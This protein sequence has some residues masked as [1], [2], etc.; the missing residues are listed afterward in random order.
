ML[1]QRVITAIILTSGFLIALFFLPTYGFMVLMA[2]TVAYGAWEWS[3]LANISS[4]VVRGLYVI[5]L[6][7]ALALSVLWL[8]FDTANKS[9]S[10]AGDMNAGLFDKHLRSMLA[11][12]CAWWALALLWIQG[13]PS[14]ALLWGRPWMCAV[15]GFLVLVPTWVALV[16]LVLMPD[17]ELLVLSVVLLV[18]LADIGAY[19]SGRAFGRHKLAE[20]VSPGKTWEG[21]IGGVSAI[22]L[23]TVCYTLIVP[24]EQNKWWAWLLLAGTTGLASVVGDLLESMVKRHRGVKDSGSILPGHGGVLDRIDSLTAALPVFALLYTLLY[25]HLS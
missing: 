5:C 17:G 22:I 25:V 4:R 23:V 9:A 3:A 8:G 14:S 15:M 24:S 16:A 7:L 19:F 21:V 20:Q 1:K 11:W 6:A 2:V 12:A 18:A 10:L 13:Y